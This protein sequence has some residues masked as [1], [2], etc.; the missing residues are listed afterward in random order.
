MWL[1]WAYSHSPRWDELCKCD[2]DPPRST[3]TEFPE[4]P[5]AKR[6]QDLQ[7]QD[8][9]EYTAEDLAFLRACGIEV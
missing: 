1:A 2:G 8:L 9:Q 3:R 6:M 5:L 4:Y 7:T